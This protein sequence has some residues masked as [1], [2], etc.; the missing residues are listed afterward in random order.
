MYGGRPALWVSRAGRWAAGEGN[1]TLGGLGSVSGIYYHLCRYHL[2]L[3]LTLLAFPRIPVRASS[4]VPVAASSSAVAPWAKPPRVQPS[5]RHIL[6]LNTTWVY[7]T[8]THIGLEALLYTYSGPSPT[9]CSLL[10]VFGFSCTGPCPERL[11]LGLYLHIHQPCS[12]SD[13]PALC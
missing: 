11:S 3:W 5:Q 10:P 1:E 4:G 8:S 12:V 6:H 9:R 13:P 7:N 2:P